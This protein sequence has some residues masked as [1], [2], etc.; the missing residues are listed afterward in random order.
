VSARD[1]IVIVVVLVVGALAASWMMLIQPKRKQAASLAT[2]VAAAQSQLDTVRSQLAQGQAARNRFGAAYAQMVRLGEA[3]PADD[4]VPSL[5]YELQHAAGD[6]HVDFRSLQVNSSAASAAPAPG[7]PGTAGAGGAQAK[8]TATATLPPGV[9]VGP[10]G[11]PAEQFTFTF[12]GNFFRLSDFFNRV[13]QFVST[14]HNQILV[15]GRLM[16]LNSIN[17]SAAP[18]GFPQIAASVSATAYM[19]PASQGLV[20]GA[21]PLGP[22]SGGSATPPASA[23][24]SSSTPTA[25]AAV[26]PPLR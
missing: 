9:T 2:Q 15:R 6:A 17:L 22:A 16:T 10:A 3:V 18:Q 14:D 7:T 24:S 19:L 5:I 8:S 1:R 25:A 26:T 23:G 13:Q 12:Q 4:N 21:T 20:A 11:F